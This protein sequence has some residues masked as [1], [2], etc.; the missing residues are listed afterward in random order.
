MEWLWKT[1][2]YILIC[3]FVLWSIRRVADAY[4]ERIAARDTLLAAQRAQQTEALLQGLEAI[5]SRTVVRELHLLTLTGL[6]L[7]RYRDT[8]DKVEADNEHPEW[9]DRVRHDTIV[10]CLNLLGRFEKLAIVAAEPDRAIRDRL[11]DAEL[12]RISDSEKN[13]RELMELLSKK[14]SQ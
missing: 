10:E 4:D 1:P 11:I 3:F 9:L 8:L 13:C 7:A 2:L 14:N 12:K 5:L 6:L